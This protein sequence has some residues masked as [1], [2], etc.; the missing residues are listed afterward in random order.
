MSLVHTF[1]STFP[2]EKD[3]FKTKESK[4]KKKKMTETT[5]VEL[6]CAKQILVNV[7]KTHSQKREKLRY[8]NC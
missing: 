8:L 4:T 1:F 7:H 3:I 6:R 2:Y 5:K